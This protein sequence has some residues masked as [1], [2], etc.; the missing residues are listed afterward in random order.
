MRTYSAVAVPGGGVY[1]AGHNFQPATYEQSD[2]FGML[3]GHMR[4]AAAVGMYLMSRSSN[5]LFSGGTSAKQAAAFGDEAPVEA[6]VY[7]RAFLDEIMLLS[8][9]P[10]YAPLCA[11]LPRPKTMLETK[12]PNTAANMRRIGQLMIAH[13]WSS[14]AVITNEY[15]IARAKAWWDDVHE[16]GTWP[17][18]YFL[19]AE[20]IAVE[21]FPDRGYEAVIAKAYQS[22]AGLKRLHHEATGLNDMR[23]GNQVPGEFQLGMMA[24]QR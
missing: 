19:S 18:V 20:A 1:K 23:A 5:F 22:P 3:G 12:S 11:E 4:V 9:D 6:A 2:M 21:A 8:H 7:E 17:D 24:R 16:P 15:H 10:D 13:R 14:L